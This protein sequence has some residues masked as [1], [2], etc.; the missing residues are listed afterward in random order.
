MFF[1]RECHTSL[2]DYSR[3]TCLYAKVDPQ[4][5]G[6]GWSLKIWVCIYKSKEF[7]LKFFYF[8]AFLEKSEC[9]ETST[10]WLPGYSLLLAGLLLSCAPQSPSRSRGP[11]LL[12]AS[13]IHVAWLA[14]DVWICNCF[15]QTDLDLLPGEK[16]CLCPV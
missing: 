1:F 4:D 8:R 9:L 10:E 7:P 6:R 2:T 3:V 16:A 13:L 5:F 15:M 14:C 12:A 11:D